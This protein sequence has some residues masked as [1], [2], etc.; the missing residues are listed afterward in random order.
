MTDQPAGSTAG[1]D[2][3]EPS[4]ARD[5]EAAVDALE[6]RVLGG[7][8]HR[9]DGGYPDDLSPRQQNSVVR[10]TGRGDEADG[11]QTPDTEPAFDIDL[12]PEDQGDPGAAPRNPD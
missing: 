8:E 11:E 5:P 12:D 3:L 6:Q 10:K 2:P 9:L 1:S 4:N 7:P